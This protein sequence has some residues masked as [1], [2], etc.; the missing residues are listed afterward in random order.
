[1]RVGRLTYKFDREITRLLNEQHEEKDPSGRMSATRLLWPTQWQIL[2]KLQAKPKEFDINSLRNFAR[3]KQCEDWLNDVFPPKIEGNVDLLEYRGFVGYPDRIDDGKF[4][5]VPHDVVNEIKS[6]MSDKWY[7]MFN[8]RE[9]D[10]VQYGH[11]LQACLYAL[12]LKLD[13]FAVTYLQADK[14][15]CRSYVFSTNQ[16]KDDVDEQI[17]LYEAALAEETIPK[18]SAKQEWQKSSKYNM[19]PRYMDMTPKELERE[20]K[21]LTKEYENN[22]K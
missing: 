3:G 1:M 20:F 18:F 12:A 7:R 2:W 16:F 8:I 14:L 15:R 9:G 19:Y 11:I 13:H 6:V 4:W 5:G 10:G 22:R 17:D 21:R